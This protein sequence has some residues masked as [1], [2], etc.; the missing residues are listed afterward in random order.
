MKRHELE[1]R[2]GDCSD[3]PMAK[4]YIVAQKGF[5][6]KVLM[7]NA[8]FT[9]FGG[10]AGSG[11]SFIMLNEAM[12][13]INEPNYRALY[14][15][16]T[17]KDV[18]SQGGLVD[19]AKKIY[20]PEIGTWRDTDPAQF[21]TDGGAVIEFGHVQNQNI[22]MIG[23][24]WKGRQLSLIGI[25]EITGI[26]FSTFTY[27]FT[28][29]RHPGKCNL[30][31]R[32]IASCNPSSEHW[33]RI[34]IDWY[35][36]E[37]GYI[38]KERDGIMRY[39]YISGQTVESVVWGDSKR[40]VYEKCRETID[41]KIRGLSRAGGMKITYENMI[42]SFVFIEGL[43]SENK[44]M[45]ADSGPD[46]IG[47]IAMQ[48]DIISAQL[49]LGNWNV[50]SEASEELIDSNDLEQ[51][52]KNTPQ[53]SA[54]KCM[55]IDVA[56]KGADSFI[57]KVWYGFHLVDIEVWP[58]CESDAAITIIRRLKE[59][60]GIPESMIVYDDN[61][62]GSFISGFFKRAVP[63][64]NNGKVIN[65]ENY[66]CLKSQ[67]ADKWAERVK[68]GGYSVSPDVLMRRFKSKGSKEKKS[69]KEWLGRERRAFRWKNR[70]LDGKLKLIPKV[71]MKSIIGKS[72]DFTE[73]W[74]MREMLE[75]VQPYTIHNERRL[76]YW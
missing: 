46:Y 22:D 7:S 56:L 51:F 53:T 48:G 41:E 67:C 11:K 5:Q 62:L 66:D 36:G 47:S 43:I 19:T 61:G 3:V 28:R 65:S 34:F 60:H 35:I 59:K 73:S 12:H 75:L 15:R 2:F 40:E 24:I 32:T 49:M 26:E 72:P 6:Q 52:F 63:F 69:L 64:L 20:P 57:A 23:Q 74:I 14:I 21:R 68:S 58:F 55:T 70:D 31:A 1:K 4:E 76:L 45:L 10:A 29:N 16:N 25:D 50:S 8:D 17:L 30:K 71:E 39:F 38:M 27:F 13:G 37:D 18:K 42:K 33:V 54:K 9:L 44:E